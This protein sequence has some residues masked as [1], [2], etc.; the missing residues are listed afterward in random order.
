LVD[1]YTFTWGAD[2]RLVGLTSADGTATFAYDP[3]G[4]LRTRTTRTSPTSR[5][6][7]T[8]T[9]T[10]IVAGRIPS[11][12]EPRPRRRHLHTMRTTADG[13]RISRTNKAT[14]TVD[15]Y[16]LRPPATA[17]STSTTRDAGGVLLASE[18][19]RYDDFGWKIARVVDVDGDG[20]A[21]A[22]TEQYVYDRDNVVMVARRGAA[23]GAANQLFLFGAGMEQRARR[24]D[25]S[26][27]RW[28]L[29]D[30]ERTVR[31]IVA[32]D[33]TLLDHVR[34]GSF[35]NIHRRDGRLGC[36]AV[37]LHRPRARRRQRDDGLPR[38]LVRPAPRLI[39]S[40]DTARVWRR[41]SEPLPATS[42]T[43]RSTRQIRPGEELG[44]SEAGGIVYPPLAFDTALKPPCP[45][46]LSM[47]AARRAF[48]NIVHAGEAVYWCRC[49]QRTSAVDPE[50]AAGRRSGGFDPSSPRLRSG[51]TGRAVR[52]P[53]SWGSF[54][55]ARALETEGFRGEVRGADGARGAEVR[56][57]VGRC[58]LHSSRASRRRASTLNVLQQ[59]GARDP[60]RRRCGGAARIRGP[61]GPRRKARH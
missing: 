11:G 56:P 36:A 60:G 48:L 29:A 9:A 30:H 41:R 14:G 8:R 19:L 18:T 51:G 47:F 33:G 35:G 61:R 27:V 37:R 28:L 20:P 46:L 54:G 25:G 15:A 43:T 57:R 32:A 44:S 23:G 3:A 7:T 59:G 22:R 53:A 17:S 26:Q 13:N 42:T 40:L 58:R 6:A 31:D 52:G 2:G 50:A 55:W 10:R 1:G 39:L 16:V 21:P 24:A 45:D 38:A 5:S 4:Q 49:A 34:Y 12:G